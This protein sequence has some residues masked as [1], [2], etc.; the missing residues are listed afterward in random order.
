M[1]LYETKNA[2]EK[3][4]ELDG[5]VFYYMSVDSAKIKNRAD[6]I[7]DDIARDVAEEF[8]QRCGGSPEKSGEVLVEMHHNGGIKH[9]TKSGSHF[10][11]LRK[12]DNMNSVLYIVK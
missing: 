1:G 2:G 11:H 12:K 10:F 5:F 4:L 8:I 9:A 6:G 7:E 3:R